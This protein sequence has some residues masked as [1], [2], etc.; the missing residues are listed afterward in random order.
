MTTVNTK[1]IITIAPILSVK[2]ELKPIVN[3]VSEKMFSVTIVSGSDTKIFN[4]FN[5]VIYNYSLI[6]PVV[7]FITIDVKILVNKIVS[8]RKLFRQRYHFY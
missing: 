4:N 8:V 3:L 6:I 5:N 1:V 7:V 2:A